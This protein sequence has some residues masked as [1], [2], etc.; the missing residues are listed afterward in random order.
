[1]LTVD[2]GRVDPQAAKLPIGWPDDDAVE[3][4]RCQRKDK[5]RWSLR[6]LHCFAE[7]LD[8]FFH[9][10]PRHAVSRP[11]FDGNCLRLLERPLKRSSVAGVNPFGER[12]A[13][14][15]SFR[16]D[17]RCGEHEQQQKAEKRNSGSHAG[18]P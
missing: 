8:E 7:R 6:R 10:R 17:R 9:L 3:V 12:A 14:S 13:R 2:S 1:M 5:V 4:V 15:L 16:R 18:H 11:H